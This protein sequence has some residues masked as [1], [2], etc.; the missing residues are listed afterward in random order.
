M[1]GAKTKM[2]NRGQVI[3]VIVC[4]A[5]GFEAYWLT[6]GFFFKETL[7]GTHSGY[8]ANTTDEQTM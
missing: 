5:K 4:Q 7:Q 6:M 8:S 1:C 2:R 3:G